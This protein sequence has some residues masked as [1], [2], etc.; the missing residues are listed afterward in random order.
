MGTRENVALIQQAYL[1]VAQGEIPRLIRMMAEDVAIH[2][3]GPEE[4]PFAG[5]YRGHEG[6]GQFFLDLASNATVEQLEPTQY[7]A[8]GDSV[9]VLGHERLTARETGLTRDTDW[10]M[11]WTVEDGQI[12]AL[13]EFHQTAAIAQAFTSRDP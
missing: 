11:V 13:R 2:L 9:A 8:D 5:I 1:A 3:P 12:T 6:A 10:V 7:I 4:I